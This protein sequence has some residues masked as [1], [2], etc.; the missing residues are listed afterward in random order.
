MEDNWDD[1]DCPPYIP[2]VEN[3]KIIRKMP[4]NLTKS[5]KRQFRENERLRWN[6]ILQEEKRASDKNQSEL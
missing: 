3:K 2:Q 5:Q 4:S 1:A 6:R